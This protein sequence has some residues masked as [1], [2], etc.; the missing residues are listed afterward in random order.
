MAKRLTVGT[1]LMHIGAVRFRYL[2]GWFRYT[3]DAKEAVELLALV[4][5]TTVVPVHYEG[6]SHFQQGREAAEEVLATA[7]TA[8]TWLDP[9]ETTTVNA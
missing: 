5:P 3:M 4:K 1:M 7:R 9:G 8:I 2:S 6:W